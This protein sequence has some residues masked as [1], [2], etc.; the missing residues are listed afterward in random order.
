[1]FVFV[2]VA[3]GDVAEGFTSTLNLDNVLVFL[4]VLVVVVVSVVVVGFIVG[5][6]NSDRLFEVLFTGFSVFS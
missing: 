5:L 3:V 2:F 4:S 6:T 1:M